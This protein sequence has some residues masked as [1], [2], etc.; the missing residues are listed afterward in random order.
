MA[1][2]NYIDPKGYRADSDRKIRRIGDEYGEQQAILHADNA[3]SDAEWA[4]GR[5]P[6]STIRIVGA[7]GWT[8]TVARNLPAQ[9]G[10]RS[11]QS[12]S[13]LTKRQIRSDSSG[14]VLS[15]R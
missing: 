11:I 2:K 15:L 14:D 6:G 10:G 13:D 5:V 3:C 4:A 12:S 7:I 9:C 1:D 8:A